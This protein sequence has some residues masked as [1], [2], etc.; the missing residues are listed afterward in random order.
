MAGKGPS[1]GAASATARSPSA[2]EPGEVTAEGDDLARTCRLEGIGHPAGHRHAADR[3]QRLVA[4]HAAAPPPQRTTPVSSTARR[5]PPSR[6]TRPPRRSGPRHP[7]TRRGGRPR[8]PG[9][10]GTA[11]TT[12]TWPGDSIRCRP[13]CW[14]SRCQPRSSI[15]SLTAARSSSSEEISMTPITG[16]PVMRSPGMASIPARNR[17][18]GGAHLVGEA[19]VALHAE[20]RDRGPGRRDRR[21]WAGARGGGRAVE[22]TR[23]RVVEEVLVA[24]ELGV[25]VQQHRHPLER[26]PVLVDVGR[27]RGDARDRQVPRG[28]RLAEPL[29]ERQEPPAEAGVDVEER[30]PLV[31]QCRQLG[32]GVD[33]AVGVAGGRADEQRGA[34]VEGIERGR[35]G[36]RGE[37]TIGAHRDDHVLHVEVVGGL[38]ERGVGRVG[39]D[40][41]RLRDP[42]RPA[43]VLAGDLH[44]EE[45]A[46]GAARGELPGRL[47]S[48]EQVRRHRHDLLLHAQAGSG[49]RTG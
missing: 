35:G 6:E 9:R 32:D 1:P 14:R 49:T 33:D 17:A 23:P 12:A 18:G 8:R 22:P 19:E 2:A 20:V 15:T 43:G 45:D 16:S 10:P 47:R 37:A 46:L 11:S 30:P 27:Q 25:A 39:G 42:T 24:Q 5:A 26:P 34:P 29:P 4:T 31:G 38:R 36:L 48:T 21:A 28:H 44:G 41:H 13:P 3:E 7:A 40:Q